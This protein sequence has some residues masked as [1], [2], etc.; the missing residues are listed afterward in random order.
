MLV[1]RPAVTPA[2]AS[3]PSPAQPDRHRAPGQQLA[4]GSCWN[5]RSSTEVYATSSA[6]TQHIVK[7]SHRRLT[8]M[9][10]RS[11]SRPVPDHLS[12][13]SCTRPH[14]EMV[15]ADV[16]AGN[17]LV[18]Q[19][20]HHPLDD[21]DVLRLRRPRVGQRSAR[22]NGWS[23]GRADANNGAAAGVQIRSARL[24]ERRTQSAAELAGCAIATTSSCN[25]TDD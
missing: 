23:P 4:A 8:T 14:G 20:I 7:R 9:P 22:R 6:A 3:L 10:F 17:P 25:T 1:T 2:P 15:G 5:A 21:R 24:A 12:L 18:R 13:C 19:R 16:L 11:S